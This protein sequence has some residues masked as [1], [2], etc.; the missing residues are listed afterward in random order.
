MPNILQTVARLG[1]NRDWPVYP[2]ILLG[3]GPLNP[4]EVATMYQTI[5][6]GDFNTPLRGIHNVLVTDDQPLKH[7]LLQVEQ[8]FDSDTVYLVQNTMQRAM[9]E[10][11]GR[12]VYDQLPSSLTLAGKISTNNDSRDSWFSS[13]GGDLQTVV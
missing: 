8:R 4:M 9:C 11:T 6:S 5:V 13:S 12:S 3:A 1:I 7:H 2:S 10:G